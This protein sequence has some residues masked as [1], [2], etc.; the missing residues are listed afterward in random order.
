MPAEAWNEWY[1]VFRPVSSDRLWFAAWQD[2]TAEM[3]NM[4]EAFSYASEYWEVALCVN[5]SYLVN[6]YQPWHRIIASGKQ[7]VPGKGYLDM[8]LVDG[9]AEIE[10]L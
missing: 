6:L 10:Q 3:L 4:M 7:N 5:A 2:R 8:I 1:A 9:K